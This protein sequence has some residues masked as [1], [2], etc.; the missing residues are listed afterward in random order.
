MEWIA[1]SGNA[2][3]NF[4][5]DWDKVTIENDKKFSE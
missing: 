4:E 3:P 2:N 1:T 5:S